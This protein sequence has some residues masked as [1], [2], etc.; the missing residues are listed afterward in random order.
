MIKID[1]G[2][3]ICG[4]AATGSG[5]SPTMLLSDGVIVRVDE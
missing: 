1:L 4:F 2:V 3:A 5:R